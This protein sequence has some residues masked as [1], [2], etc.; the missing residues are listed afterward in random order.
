MIETRRLENVAIF[1]KTILLLSVFILTNTVV[2]SLT[3]PK[4]SMIE[5][6]PKLIF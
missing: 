6:A 3:K 2:E 4:N 1:F 5:L